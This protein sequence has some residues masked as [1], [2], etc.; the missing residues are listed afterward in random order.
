MQQRQ[1]FIDGLVEHAGWDRE[2]AEQHFT[3]FAPMFEIGNEIDFLLTE[4][5]RLRHATR[6]SQSPRS[7]T[8]SKPTASG[9]CTKTSKAHLLCVQLRH[10]HRHHHRRPR[11]PP[12]ESNRMLERWPLPSPTLPERTTDRRAGPH[13]TGRA[14]DRDGVRRAW[15]AGRP[16][17]VVCPFPRP[18]QALDER[19]PPPRRPARARAPRDSYQVSATL[20]IDELMLQL[21]DKRIK[22]TASEKAQWRR[23]D[24]TPFSYLACRH[25]HCAV[26]LCW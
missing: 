14:V 19:H 9:A 13:G 1:P 22:Q 4:A 17:V 7:S 8:K 3:Q 15:S 11:L 21:L 2:F 18:R 26:F 10:A 6:R 12:G 16:A 5:K 20:G 25:N 23:L 24:S